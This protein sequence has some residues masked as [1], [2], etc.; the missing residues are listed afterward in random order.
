MENQT[1]LVIYALQVLT[2]LL[3]GQQCRCPEDAVPVPFACQPEQLNMQVDVPCIRNTVPWS[4]DSNAAAAAAFYCRGCC[5]WQRQ[6]M[7]KQLPTTAVPGNCWGQ[8]NFPCFLKPL[9]AAAGWQITPIAHGNHKQ[10][11]QKQNCRMHLQQ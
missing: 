8:H 3:E 7:Y 6:R 5:H 1:R 9:T 4:A 10:P 11:K 2:C